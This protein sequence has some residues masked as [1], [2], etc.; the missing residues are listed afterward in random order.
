MFMYYRN[1]FKLNEPIW[2]WEALLYVDPLG[3]TTAT[4]LIENPASEITI[5]SVSDLNSARILSKAEKTCIHIFYY[6]HNTL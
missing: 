2:I 3:P 1:I 5:L 6:L 4:E